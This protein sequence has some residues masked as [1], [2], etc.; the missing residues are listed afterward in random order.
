MKA[1][2]RKREAGSGKREAGSGKREVEI[3]GAEISKS[4][5]R[6]VSRWNGWTSCGTQLPRPAARREQLRVRSA[7]SELKIGV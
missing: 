6:V 3:G 7:L 2:S 4:L 1:E 5:E